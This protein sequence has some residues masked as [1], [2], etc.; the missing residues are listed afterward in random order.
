MNKK[1]V[2]EKL[3]ELPK[4][5]GVYIYRNDAKKIIY[6]G[7]AVNLKNR[8]LSYFRNKD[9]DIK[10]QA[11]VEN[12]D[13]LE[14]IICETEIEALILE[15]ELIKRYRPKY[16]IDWKDDKNYS[17]IKVTNEEYPTIIVV[18]Q[19]IDD[20]ATYIGPF[21]D[22]G[23][24]RLAL[25][26]L[27]KVFPYCTCG[28]PSDKVCLYY[29]L[30]LCPGH[31]PKY[32]SPKDYK[33]NIDG[34]LSY[35]KGDK[36]KVKNQLKKQM[37]EYAKNHEFEKAAEVRNRIMA[38]SKIKFQSIFEEN[39]EIKADKAL[40]GLQKILNLNGLPERIEC[41]DISNISGKLAVGSMVVFKH[42]IP[43]KDDYRRFEIKTVKQIDDFAM[44]REVQKR[45]FSNLL[46][47]LSSLETNQGAR[48]KVDKSFSQIPDLIVIDGGKGQLSSALEII[49]PL[50]IQTKVIGLAK[51]LEEIYFFE[52]LP[53]SSPRKRGSRT[54]EEGDIS[55]LNKRTDKFKCITLPE[56][57]ESKF[58]LQRIR[59]EAHRFAITYHRNLRSKEIR[60]SGLDKIEGIGPV[61]KKKLINCFGSVDKIK[62]ATIEELERVVNKKIAAK[63][64]EEL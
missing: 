28:L 29:H 17:Y 6:V 34:L 49:K 37:N 13:D 47:S 3:K 12:I 41:Y 44:H 22:A 64:K 10:T 11:L 32:I 33:K 14:W 38:L 53:P 5:P 50:K 62:K 42:G 9:L 59:D 40:S 16:N 19:I 18:R 8:V 1:I 31:G 61:T 63:I 52:P 36:E 46:S 21:V 43:S 56:N 58:L 48:R 39:D 51:R 23:A 25:K 15:S 26:T 57:S 54:D 55:G 30:K 2:Q 20:K 27:R 35:I 4:N 45:R 60:K 24:V 7:K